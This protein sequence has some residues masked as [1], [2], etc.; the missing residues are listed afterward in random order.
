MTS[1]W[2]LGDIFKEKKM[3]NVV[4]NDIR[5]YELS[6]DLVREMRWRCI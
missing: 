6:F 3:C 1:V 4:C 5:V 2:L